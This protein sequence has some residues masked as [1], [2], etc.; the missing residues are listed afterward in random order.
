[1]PAARMAHALQPTGP[2]PSRTPSRSAPRKINANI[3]MLSA[4]SIGEKRSPTAGG[5]RFAGRDFRP[6]INT[7]MP[8]GTFNA[9]SHGHEA[10]ERIA[11]A[12][13]GPAT[14][15]VAT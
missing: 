12:T 5:T 13:D 2:L 1:M 14:D 9:K 3:A 8:S 10:T 6:S 11:A 4:T 15:E 7:M